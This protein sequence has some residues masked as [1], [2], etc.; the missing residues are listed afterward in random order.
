M[1]YKMDERVYVIRYVNI[2]YLCIRYLLG[3]GFGFEFGFGFGM[4]LD[5]V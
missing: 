5:W 4:S 3:F 1:S 2:I